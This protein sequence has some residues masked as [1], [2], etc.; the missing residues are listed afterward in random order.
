MVS[1]ATAKNEIDPP[2]AK[3][4]TGMGV[5]QSLMEIIESGRNEQRELLKNVNK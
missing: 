5:M 1:I 2:G 3:Q 4:F